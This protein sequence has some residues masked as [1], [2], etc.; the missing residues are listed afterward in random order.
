MLSGNFLYHGNTTSEL[1][2]D[3]DLATFRHNTGALEE[4]DWIRDFKREIIKG[5][6]RKK[7]YTRGA[8]IQKQTTKACSTPMYRL[9]NESLQS[10]I[11]MPTNQFI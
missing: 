4:I 6:K 5:R 10:L 11:S 2:V 9:K 1:Q 3:G 8:K 7:Y